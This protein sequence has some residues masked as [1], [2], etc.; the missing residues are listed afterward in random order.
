MYGQES[1][2]ASPSALAESFDRSWS[3]GAHILALTETAARLVDV[4]VSFPIANFT[5]RFAILSAKA[6]TIGV[7]SVGV[8]NLAEEVLQTMFLTR[9]K[10]AWAGVLIACAL[11][12]GT[13][14]VLGRQADK[15][16]PTSANGRRD[17][18]KVEFPRP[19]GERGASNA[20]DFIK[21]SRGVIITRLE[22]E[23]ALARA[24]LDRTRRRVVS[25]DDP[26]AIQA[27]RAVE[28][29]ESL[30]ARID[31]VLVDAVDRFPTMFDF[32]GARSNQAQ[33]QSANQRPQHNSDRSQ[34]Q[35]V[36]THQREDPDQ[37]QQPNATAKGGG[38][39]SNK[40]N[41]N[42]VAA[43]HLSVSEGNRI[44]DV[45]GQTLFQI[46]LR[47]QG[48]KD[49]THLLVTADLS[50]NLQFVT[51]GGMSQ[52]S[53]VT[54]RPRENAL[55]FQRI[56]KVGPG[57]EVILGFVARVT[58]PNPTLATCR[59]SVTH[60]DLAEGEKLEDMAAVTVVPKKSIFR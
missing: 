12:A 55:T 27:K 14:A 42:G 58:D 44:V 22:E 15:S 3:G 37:F 6:P 21:Q 4:A 57:E 31:G 18:R 24:R 35:N 39:D 8:A 45:G 33:P 17:Q 10:L 46:R 53:T 40:R 30:L 2:G 16:N 56:E 20:P 23:L 51:G 50:R 60:E 1:P 54:V 25:S 11:T 19:A 34:W 48:T 29:I 28:E 41:A 43:V 26:A 13:V 49:A 7:V 5:L 32:S 36:N 38:Y 52:K 47:N 9:L 59:V